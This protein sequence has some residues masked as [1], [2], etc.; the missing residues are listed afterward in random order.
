M[1]V[2]RFFTSDLHL[3]HK[4]ILEYDHRPF[5]TI[6]EHDEALISNWNEIVHPQDK[7]YLLGDVAWYY[8]KEKIAEAL[9]RLQGKIYLVRG[10]HDWL[11]DKPGVRERF[12]QR[13]NLMLL[14]F[15]GEGIVR[16]GGTLCLSLCHYAM[17]RWL[18]SHRPD[19][20]HLYGHSHGNGEDHGDLSMDV[21]IMLSQYHPIPWEVMIKVMKKRIERGLGPSYHHERK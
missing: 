12:E 13:E 4:N 3:G 18:N 1:T 19:S 14:R 6:E 15:K 2:N 16:P 9:G 5:A 7:V 10:N 8:H 20:F 17:R 21:G 11:L